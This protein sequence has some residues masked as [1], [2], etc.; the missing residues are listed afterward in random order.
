LKILRLLPPAAASLAA[1]VLLAPPS[2]WAWVPTGWSLD[3]TQRDVRV[4]NNFTDS[5]ANDN[6]TPDANFPDRFGAEMAIWKATVEWG[7]E[8]HGDGQGDPGQPGGLGSGGANFDATFQ[9]SALVAGQV[10]DNTH[11]E[12]PGCAGGILAFTQS[13]VD[14]TGWRTFY[15]QCWVWVDG[16]EQNWTP[17][18]GYYDLQGIAT[19]EYGHSLGLGHSS[20]PLATMFATPPSNGRTWRSLNADD[21]AGIQAIYGVKDP[22]K[23]IIRGAS[24]KGSVLTLGGSNFASGGN[25]IWFTQRGVGGDGDPVKT[26]AVESGVGGTLLEVQVPSGAGSGDVLVY[27]T[28][29]DGETLSN[30][31]PFA[32]YPVGC[33]APLN[34]CDAL[35]NSTGKPSVMGAIGSQSVAAN[36]ITL[37][38]FGSPANSFGIFF[39]SPT[40]GVLPVGDGL[41]CLGGPFFRLAAMQ[42]DGTGRALLPLDLTLPP[43][44]GGQITSGSVW[45]F[46]WWYR[47]IPGGPSGYNFSDALRLPFCD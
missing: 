44:P 36:D 15:Y 39:Y 18:T 26:L 1:L 3:V 4:F 40:S 6:Q 41:I 25:E 5:Q 34:Y 21:V 46:Q 11:S 33:P 27:T 2:A 32:R 38:S 22:T 35:P 13:F 23:P 12:L 42:A 31:W 30:A 43:K 37:I 28:L 7:S 10:G 14:G 24:L 8:L 45:H 17:K 20:D 47:D 16:P 29:G 9:G 19:H